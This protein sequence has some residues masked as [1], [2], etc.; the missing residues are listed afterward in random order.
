VDRLLAIF[1][2]LSILAGLFTLAVLMTLV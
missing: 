1:V 2:F